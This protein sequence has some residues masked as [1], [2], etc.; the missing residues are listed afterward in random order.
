[1]DSLSLFL[2]LEEK[3]EGTLKLG[4]K[5]EE[6]QLDGTQLVIISPLMEVT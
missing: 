1:M 2:L 6:P 5:R 3:R 4:P